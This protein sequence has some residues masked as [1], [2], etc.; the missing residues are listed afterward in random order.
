M[1]GEL[2]EERFLQLK[3]EELMIEK[4]HFRLLKESYK[5]LC[6]NNPTNSSYEILFKQA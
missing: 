6:W 4:E 1:I 2:T 5:D 3:I